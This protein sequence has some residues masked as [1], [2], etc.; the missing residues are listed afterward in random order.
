[1]CIVFLMVVFFFFPFS[2]KT[3]ADHLPPVNSCTILVLKICSGYKEASK[4]PKRRSYLAKRNHLLIPWFVSRLFFRIYW[5]CIPFLS[6]FWEGRFPAFQACCNWR[7]FWI[8]RVSSM[9]WAYASCCTLTKMRVTHVLDQ[10]A[11]HMFWKLKQQLCM[12]L[13]L[14]LN[15]KG[16]R[17]VRLYH[18]YYTCS[19]AW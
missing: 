7:G 11:L 2:S 9:T 18:T 16:W 14:T 3:W 15:L 10:N 6:G 12:S 17:E 4:L 5:I 19:W 8:L 13:L 1:M